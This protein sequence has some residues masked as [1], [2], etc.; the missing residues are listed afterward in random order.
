ML[1]DD[2]I[3]DLLERPKAI[4]R[5]SP[6]VGY[7]TEG[8]HRRADLTL[9]GAAGSSAAMFSV[10]VRQNLRFIE[11][12]SVGLRY[13]SNLAGLGDVTL[14]RYNGSHGETSRH[15]DGHYAKPHIH[16]IT[17]VELA[18]GSRE[19]KER[20]RTITDRY[21]TLEDALRTFFSDLN[22]DGVQS[23]FPELL[24]RRMFNGQ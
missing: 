14:V 15:P 7:K 9:A 11:S 21:A 18:S 12:F 22:I 24:E 20:H 6:R 13:H 4:A 10:F 16:R 3:Q 8:G 5:R 23:F 1:T 17:E 19:P 2:E